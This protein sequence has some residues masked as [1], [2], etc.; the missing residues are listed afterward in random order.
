MPAAGSTGAQSWQKLPDQRLLRV[1][2]LLTTKLAPSTHG[3]LA[4][5]AFVLV[6][7]RKPRVGFLL[8][9]HRHVQCTSAMADGSLVVVMVLTVLV[10]S[11]LDTDSTVDSDSQLTH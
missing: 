5:N 11:S 2:S 4:H 10:R 3:R 7:C 1:E 8:R 6:I 9:S